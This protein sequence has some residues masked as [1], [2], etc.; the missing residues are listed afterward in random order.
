MLSN[1][2]T[3][4]LIIGGKNMEVKRRT[5]KQLQKEKDLQ[6]LNTFARKVTEAYATSEREYSQRNVAQDNNLTQK[7]LRDLMDYAIITDLVSIE[8][9]EK[10]LKKSIE[11]QQRKS[12]EAGGSSISHHKELMKKRVNFIAYFYLPVEIERI[13]SDVANN[14]RYSIDHFKEKYNIES[15]KVMKLILQRAIVENISSDR[16][17]EKIIKRSLKVNATESAKQ[18][19]EYLRNE[20]IKNRNSQ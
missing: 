17:V 1:L 3:C 10:V 16:D 18:Y 20:R 13:A 8:I 2:K 7:A 11:N 19:F 6:E 15:G 4:C 5:F 9:A 14:P 12:Q